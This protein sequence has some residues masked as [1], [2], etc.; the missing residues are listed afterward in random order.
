MEH[1]KQPLIAYQNIY[2]SL[3]QGGI[4]FGNFEDHRKE[5]FHISP[6]LS[7]L[8]E[9]IEKEFKKINKRCYKK[10]K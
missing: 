1:I 10:R 9:R 5:I 4:L 6:N 3:E 8:R 2:D 7:K